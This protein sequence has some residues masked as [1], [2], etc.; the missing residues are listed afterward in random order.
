MCPEPF[1]AL[2]KTIHR[3]TGTTQTRGALGSSRD[4]GCHGGPG[5]QLARR[6]WRGTHRNHKGRSCTK[7][8]SKN[9]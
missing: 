4:F 7:G 3:A 1:V 2:R 5:L 9:N 8:P 6:A